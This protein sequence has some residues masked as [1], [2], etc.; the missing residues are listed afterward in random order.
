MA[1]PRSEPL[2]AEERDIFR[3]LIGIMIPADPE[4]ALPSA[5]D[6]LIL[7][8]CIETLGRDA[9]AIRI[10]LGELMRIGFLDLPADQAEAKAM[11]LLGENRAEVQALS[12]VVVAAYYRDDRVMLAY[13][14][15]PRAPF[16][17]GHSLPQGDWSL[18]D[19]VKQKEPFWRDD[20]GA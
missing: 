2:T 13:G 8:D 5:D 20:R 19:V 18:L 6:A 3:R 7:E 15:E 4:M 16:P 14:R 1:D 17:K 9:A 11:A 10:L 12:R